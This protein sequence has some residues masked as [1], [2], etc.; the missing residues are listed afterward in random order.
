MLRRRSH[1]GSSGLVDGASL[2]IDGNKLEA[3]VVAMLVPLVTA[4]STNQ[5]P[6]L[7]TNSASFISADQ[8]PLAD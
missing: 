6:N 1:R 4:I 2:S 3:R 8:P 7:E 5:D